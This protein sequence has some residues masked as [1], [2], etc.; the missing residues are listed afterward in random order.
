MATGE[1]GR[2]ARRE[3]LVAAIAAAVVSVA[4]V[5]L[6]AARG[7][8]GA[9][10]NDDWTYYDIAF[11]LV[12]TGRLRLDGWTQA[13]FAGQAV[14]AAPVIEVFGEK[15]APLQCAVAVAGAVG[16]W[17]CYVTVRRLLPA[18]PAALC[19]ACLAL[20]PLYGVLSTSFMTDVPAFTLQMLTLLAGMQALRAA[21]GSLRWFTFAMTLGLLAFSVREYAVAAGL[22]VALT[23]IAQQRHADRRLCRQAVAVSALWV[24]L[25]VALYWWRNTLD[26][27]YTTQLELTARS[28]GGA[29]RTAGRAAVTLGL[30]VAP[31]VVA[32][33]PAR[34]ARLAWR[35]SRAGS[36]VVVAGWLACAVF[37]H[38]LLGNYLLRTS[39]YSVTVP[40]VAPRILPAW[41]WVALHAAGL[42][43][44]CS[45]RWP[46]LPSAATAAPRPRWRVRGPSRRSH[47]RSC[48]R[49]PPERSPS[50]SM[51]S[52]TPRS[53][54]ATCYPWCR[55]SPR[56]RSGWAGRATCSCDPR[57]GSAARP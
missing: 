9:A 10:R 13:L 39:A 52:P 3:S 37:A 2:L 49:R 5:A 56:S 21:P 28:F 40:G 33:S 1:L 44:C 54:T 41:L 57:S 55:S 22:A 35:R 42:A 27:S 20:G 7:A 53:S 17:A 15:I 19:V 48:S 8:L 16:L 45:A 24:A 38:D 31:A 4:H 26:N 36:I 12:S 29:A 25:L 30:L 34:L 32:I 46:S 51:P 18:R 6:A 14:M 23:F 50:P 43:C 11:R 47:W